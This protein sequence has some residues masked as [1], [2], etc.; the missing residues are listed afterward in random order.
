MNTEKKLNKNIELKIEFFY[1]YE[2]H[3]AFTHTH[4]RIRTRPFANTHTHIDNRHTIQPPASATATAIKL[5]VHHVILP[6]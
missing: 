5:L 3:S 1:S 2:Q 6:A 4:R